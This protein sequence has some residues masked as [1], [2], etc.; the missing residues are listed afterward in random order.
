MPSSIGFHSKLILKQV[1]SPSVNEPY[2]PAI[3]AMSAQLSEHFVEDADDAIHAAAVM[4]FIIGVLVQQ[5]A[6]NAN[7]DTLNQST[8]DD[9]AVTTVNEVRTIFNIIS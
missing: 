9:A 7:V 4:Q 2:Y 8:V 5:E 6:T 3:I 1:R